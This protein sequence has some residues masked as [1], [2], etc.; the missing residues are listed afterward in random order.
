[1]L[2]ALEDYASVV[3]IN[4]SRTDAL[5][6]RGRYNFANKNWHTT[7]ADF[8]LMIQREPHN[9]LARSVVFACDMNGLV[10]PPPFPR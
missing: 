4:P 10:V 5:L 8:T 3:R 1:M 7:I 6:K 2:L 9:A